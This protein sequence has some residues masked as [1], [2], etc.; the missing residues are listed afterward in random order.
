LVD[1]GLRVDR[2]QPGATYEVWLSGRIDIESAPDMG[3]V[4]LH[5]LRLPACRTLTIHSE[6][7]VYIDV[8][9][10]ATLLEILKA[11]RLLGKQLLLNG[12][13]ERPRYLLE[14]TRLL[15]LFNAESAS[16]SNISP[17]PTRP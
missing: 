2:E 9:G 10:L 3:K 4:L 14:V 7:V 8:A 12:L 17:V 11:A 1:A 15:H 13:R 16:T 5:R 6:G